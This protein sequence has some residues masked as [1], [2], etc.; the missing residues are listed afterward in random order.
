[1]CCLLHVH[2]VRTTGLHAKER[3]TFAYAAACRQC[4]AA[5]DE[6]SHVAS[7]VLTYPCAPLNCCVAYLS[8]QTCC[9]SC[10]SKHRAE[11]AGAWCAAGAR[12]GTWADGPRL[13]WVAPHCCCV[14]YAA[15]E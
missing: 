3:R 12:F 6:T 8:L 14:T 5:L 4:G 13:E 7:H 2:A 9:R 10:N 1:M 15:S 11:E